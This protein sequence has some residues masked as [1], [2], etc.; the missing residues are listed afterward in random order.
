MSGLAIS[1]ADGADDIDAW[2]D[3]IKDEDSASDPDGK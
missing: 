2:A 1:S 3:R